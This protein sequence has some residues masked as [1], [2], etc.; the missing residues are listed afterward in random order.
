MKQTNDHPQHPQWQSQ[1]FLLLSVCISSEFLLPSRNSLSILGSSMLS[2][3]FIFSLSLLGA[4]DS[5]WKLNVTVP[6][7]YFL[8]QFLF[9][10]CLLPS[11]HIHSHSSNLWFYL[12][13]IDWFLPNSSFQSMLSWPLPTCP[14]FCF[15]SPLCVL[16]EPQIQLAWNSVHHFALPVVFSILLLM[17]TCTHNPGKKTRRWLLHVFLFSK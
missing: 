17:P 4:S 3:W 12:E 13:S 5:F 8:S 7:S 11:I 2:L 1:S 15:T 6:Q 10:N 9:L 14:I 16:Q